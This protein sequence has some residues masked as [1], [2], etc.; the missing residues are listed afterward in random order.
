MK[1]P[2]L[3]TRLKNAAAIAAPPRSI[4]ADVMAQIGSTRPD[5]V[6]RSRWNRPFW[7]H[8]YITA[9]VAAVS[10]IAA[11]FAFVFFMAAP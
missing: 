2:D 8:P 6:A 10:G 1:N 5:A 9:A 4:A 3:E 11:V 7:N